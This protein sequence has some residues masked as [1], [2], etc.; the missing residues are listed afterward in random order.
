MYK[1]KVIFTYKDESTITVSNSSTFNL[2]LA[3]K[4]HAQYGQTS[5]HENFQLYPK[6]NHHAMDWTNVMVILD[7]GGDLEEEAL[8]PEIKTG[9]DK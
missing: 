6:K 1:W 9:A 8:R 3:K 5:V 4:Y 7:A 2:R